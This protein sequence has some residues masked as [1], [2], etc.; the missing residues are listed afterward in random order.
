MRRFPA[1]L[2]GKA[3][4]CPPWLRD[5]GKGGHLGDCG[6]L[7]PCPSGAS[8]RHPSLLRNGCINFRWEHAHSGEAAPEMSPVSGK[9]GTEASVWVGAQPWTWIPGIVG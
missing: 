8:E 4:P 5:P 9:E 6:Y 3:R 2:Y 7:K 1:T